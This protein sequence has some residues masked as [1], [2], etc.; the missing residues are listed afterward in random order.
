M[1]RHSLESCD[2]ENFAKGKKNIVECF[3]HIEKIIKR[4][5]AGR[6]KKRAKTAK[7]D[8]EDVEMEDNDLPEETAQLGG[9]SPTPPAAKQSQS[10]SSSSDDDYGKAVESMKRSFDNATIVT[11]FNEPVD[12]CAIADKR[13]R[14]HFQGHQSKSGYVWTTG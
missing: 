8:D 5:Q 10:K 3:D 9:E 1:L 6:D 4:D 11:R 7:D 2:N 13:K 14:M 12:I